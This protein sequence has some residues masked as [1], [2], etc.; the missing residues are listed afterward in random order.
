MTA[1]LV[2]SVALLLVALYCD[3]K[4]TFGDRRR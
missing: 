3:Y 2:G 1:L 4:E